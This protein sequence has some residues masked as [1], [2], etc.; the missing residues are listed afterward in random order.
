MTDVLDAI[1][2]ESRAVIVDEL[3]RRD[4]ALLAQL[5]AAQT[6]TTEQRKAVN[7]TLAIAVVKNLGPDQAPDEYGLAIE[8]AVKA[9]LDAWPIPPKQGDGDDSRARSVAQPAEHASSATRGLEPRTLTVAWSELETG[10][11]ETLLAVLLY[12]E[13]PRATRVLPSKGD[14]GVDVLNP[15]D[16]VPEA[17]DVFQIK[18]FS[19]ALTPSQ[20]KQVENSFRRVLIGLVRRGIP[21][22]DWY[23]VCP[24]DNTID[25]QTDWFD[26]MPDKVIADMFDDDKFVRLE[27]TKQLPLTADEKA[28]ITAWRNAPGRIIKWEGRPFCITLAAKYPYVI[29][30]YF[31]GGREHLDKAIANL[32]SIVSGPGSSSTQRSGTGVLTPADVRSHLDALKSVLDTDPH[33]IYGF[34]V[35]PTPPDLFADVGLAHKGFSV[36]RTAPGIVVADDLIA[37]TQEP[38]SDG[39]TLTFR[40][41]QRFAEAL[42]E[43]PV[44]IRLEFST[45]DAAFDRHAFNMW[46]KYGTPL[47]APA[48]VEA[49]LPGGLG[50]RLSGARAEVS[51]HSSGITN[52]AR[53][54][55]RKPDGS[56]GSELSFS[57]TT[58]SGPDGTGI[59]QHGRDA[60]GYLTYELLADTE[61]NEVE[62]SFALTRIVGA[63]LAAALPPIEFLQDLRAPNAVQVAER[64]G[65]F[66]DF[67]EIPDDESPKFPE[68][69]MNY[70]RALAVIQTHTSTPILIPDLTRV[71]RQAVDAAVEASVLVSGQAVISTWESMAMATDATLKQIDPA[72]N[73]DLATEYQLL[74]MEKLVVSVGEQDLVL[75]TVAKF[76]LSARYV[77]EDDELVA[78]PYRNDTLQKTFSPNP[79]AAGELERH[80]L[81]RI[82]GPIDESAA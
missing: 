30:Y 25:Q 65:P 39:W 58:T 54:R 78:R 5:R 32:V 71:T 80:V 41:Y 67:R 34:S 23:L 44:P 22:A 56:T 46:R 47:T 29:D 38:L 60:T 8:R 18:Y 59:R 24:V 28:K 69:V 4:P 75:G 42:R 37:A 64:L 53:F 20:K 19:K 3:T 52:G 49:D 16:S 7:R 73:V 81:G 50:D 17:F 61:T 33:F 76:A 10:Q 12:N 82:V 6:P 68:S 43:R 79:D 14:Y 63:E 35:D 11:A 74:A 77:V 55:I 27:K 45:A 48:E 9:F 57:I 2:P 72:R 1:S 36:D 13:H 26:A 66:R 21:L 51:L 40:I 70:L 15:S 31:G 62:W